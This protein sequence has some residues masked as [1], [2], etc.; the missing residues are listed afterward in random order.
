MHRLALAGILS[1]G[2]VT[3]VTLSLVTAPSV[4]AAQKVAATLQDADEGLTL[5]RFLE[6]CAYS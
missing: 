5:R 3:S 2:I 6:P 1:L 4:I